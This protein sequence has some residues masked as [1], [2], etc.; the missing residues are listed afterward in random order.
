MSPEYVRTAGIVIEYAARRARRQLD[1][2]LECTSHLVCE[3]ITKRHL[4]GRLDAKWR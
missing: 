4:K 1:R 3:N 2:L